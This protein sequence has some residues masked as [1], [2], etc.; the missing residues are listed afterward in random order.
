MKMKNVRFWMLAFVAMCFGIAF[1]D[2]PVYATSNVT[3]KV[4]QKNAAFEVETSYGIDGLVRADYP[5][6]IQFTI[7][8]KENFNGVLRIVPEVEWEM[9]QVAYGTEISLAAG[10]E[11][12]YQLTPDT[13]QGNGKIRVEILDEKNKV[14]YAEEQVLSS[15]KTDDNFSIGILSDDYTAFSYFDGLQ[16]AVSGNEIYTEIFALNEGN[17]PE[18]KKLL[19]VF[20]Y[21]II[22]NFDTAKL[23]EKQYEALKGF[24][25]D[26]G[27]LI[28]GLGNHYQ[29][30]LHC[31]QDDFLTGTLGDVKK[32]DVTWNCSQELGNMNIETI[33]KLMEEEKSQYRDESN[34]SEDMSDEQVVESTE[35][36]SAG[37]TTDLTEDTSNDAADEILTTL[38]LDCVSF[39]LDGGKPFSEKFSKDAAF[40]KKYGAGKIVV[41]SY[42]L[43]MEPLI[44]ADKRSRIA[45]ILIEEGVSDEYL[46][47]LSGYNDQYHNM[48]ERFNI[49]KM[50]DAG[51]KP[52]ALL[53]GAILVLYIVLIG[54]V[55]YLVL[56]KKGKRELVWI[57]IP[58]I[59]V[60]FT[61]VI[62]LTGFLYRITKPLVTTCALIELN[63]SSKNEEVY[64]TVICPKAKD[65]EVEFS[66]AYGNFSRNPYDYSYSVFGN[67]SDASYKYMIMKKGD[68][69]RMFFHNEEAF[70]DNSFVLE[71]NSENAIGS[72]D[73]DLICKT[74]GFEGTVTNNTCYDLKE[75]VVS[76]ESR[77]CPVGDIKKGETVTI[78]S[79]KAFVGT[80]NGS[81]DTSRNL[82]NINVDKELANR[83]NNTMETTVVAQNQEQTGYVWGTV[84]SYKPDMVENSKVEQRG[85]AVLYDTFFTEYE[86]VEGGKYYSS[87]DHK[88]VAMQGDYGEYERI[89]YS[90]DVIITYYFDDSKGLSKLLM[91][92]MPKSE[93]SYDRLAQVYAYNLET[94]DYD[95]IFVD[96]DT[97]S[98][99]E[100]KKYVK[101][102][103]M[104]L[105][106][107][108][109][110]MQYNTYIPRISAWGV[111]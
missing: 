92:E 28:L 80:G 6:L 47:R 12:T 59:A 2:V 76:F 99:Q 84:V 85:C 15:M 51:R 109:T 103:A 74:T 60:V 78:D 83:I 8:S 110:D 88:A 64:T 30:V 40:Q 11:K 66:G 39:A 54:P 55:L 53:Y 17:F 35:E 105:K 106:Y 24:V 21:I 68:N 36:A 75:V 50:A 101:D 14:V 104:I 44:S 102:G 73:A 22:D 10:E 1:F 96:T 4:L 107:T 98:E 86:D 31:F 27:T 70:Q 90:G 79:T 49:G 26:G 13:I 42:A 81:F 58:I 97:V 100:L 23:N 38:Y 77:L 48:D 61:V 32:Q 82:L 67:E 19:S 95:P 25:E 37:Q 52:N 46:R 3:T 16:L 33:Q 56:K 20:Q 43:S 65:Y 89:I 72:L 69:H 41:L 5:V 18:E 63:D 34:V 7:T 93:N 45:N 62:Y 9:L 87:I 57:G 108:P 29:N 91:N 111:E 71:G 94:G